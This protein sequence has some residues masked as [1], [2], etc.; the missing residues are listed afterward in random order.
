MGVPGLKRP[1]GRSRGSAGNQQK[2]RSSSAGADSNA[3]DAVSDHDLDRAI[4]P[5]QESQPMQQEDAA[6]AEQYAGDMEIIYNA[7]KV[8]LAP[9]PGH[10][11][12]DTPCMRSQTQPSELLLRDT[13]PSVMPCWLFRSGRDVLTAHRQQRLLQCMSGGLQVGRPT[14]QIFADTI[15]GCTPIFQHQNVSPAGGRTGNGSR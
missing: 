14:C 8:S 4:V 2:Q 13:L 6:G 5:F 12:R 15:C 11:S 1:R 7:D 10:Q 9:L 3:P